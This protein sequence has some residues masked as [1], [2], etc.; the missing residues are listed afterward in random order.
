MKGIYFRSQIKLMNMIL[1]RL[2]TKEDIPV[3]I[4]A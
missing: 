1:T 3:L 2:P 4:R